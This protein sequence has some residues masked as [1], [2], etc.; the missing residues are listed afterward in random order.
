M[1]FHLAENASNGE[2]LLQ[3]LDERFIRRSTA[4]THAQF[5]IFDAVALLQKNET[6][7]QRVQTFLAAHPREV[8]ERR[9]TRN[10]ELGTQNSCVAVQIEA[11]ENNLYPRWGQ[12][13]PMRHQ[14]AKIAAGR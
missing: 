5:Q 11:I 14:V 9:R 4:A 12:I 13:E 3:L 2:P 8:A 7:H 10:L 1:K 6:L